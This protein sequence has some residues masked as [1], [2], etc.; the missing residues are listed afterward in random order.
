MSF[1]SLFGGDSTS[2]STQTTTNNTDKRLVAD[3]GSVGISS[4]SSNV[5]FNQ[6]DAGAITAGTNVALAG[7]ANNANNMDHLL[8]AA[9]KLFSQQQAALDMNSQL[10]KALATSTQAAYQ[11][12]AANAQGNK[13]I[14]YAVIAVIGIV[15]INILGKKV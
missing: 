13:P 4:D 2:S 11:D 12:A 9:D 14:M 5:S 6:L 3:G 7:I 8:A 1:L 10:T 15:A